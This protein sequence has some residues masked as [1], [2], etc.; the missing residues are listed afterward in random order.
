MKIPQ[1]QLIE[2]SEDIECLALKLDLEL[3][4]E[5]ERGWKAGIVLD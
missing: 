4:S 2:K 1:S 3:A 5:I